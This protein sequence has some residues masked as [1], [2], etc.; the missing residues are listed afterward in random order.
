MKLRRFSLFAAIS[1]SLVGLWFFTAGSACQK[2]TD[3]PVEPTLA[4]VA[5]AAPL[6]LAGACEQAVAPIT[7]TSKGRV[8]ALG[9]V[10]G[11]LR[12]AQ[13]ALTL[14]GVVDASG[15]WRGGTTTVVQTGD[16]LDRGDQEQAIIDWFEAL[17]AQASA[18][19]GAFIWLVGNHE[20]MN[21]AGD[22]RYV[23]PGGFDDFGGPAAR[24]AA[25]SPGGAYARVMAGQRVVAIV[26]GIAFSH[27]GI[28]ETWADQVAQLN[29][30]TVCWLAAASPNQR[31]P[32][33]LV[34][35]D[36]PVW[37][38]EFGGAAVDCAAVARALARLGA[39]RMVVGHTVQAGGINSTC[40]GAVWR[41]DAGM[42]AHYGGVPQAVEFVAGAPPRIIVAAT[43]TAN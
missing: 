5:D 20:A 4:A 28:N 26:D 39:S 32:A 17:E 42:S 41:I 23:T 40:D 21:A 9:D 27:A 10:H 11:D 24:A 19:G 29:S 6:P 16:I 38:R 8:V 13:A 35:Q 7:S 15:A 37:T 14:A 43:T 1:W 12:A 2:T 36:G 22:V 34:A 30:E 31:P 25:F 33:G 3:K 18:A